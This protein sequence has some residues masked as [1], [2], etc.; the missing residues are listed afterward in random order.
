MVGDRQRPRRLVDHVERVGAH[1]AGEEADADHD[2]G[3]GHQ[4][5]RE[6]ILLLTLSHVAVAFVALLALLKPSLPLLVGAGLAALTAGALAVRDYG[7][8]AFVAVMSVPLAVIGMVL[9]AFAWGHRHDARHGMRPFIAL[10]ALAA[11]VAVAAVTMNGVDLLRLHQSA[12]SMPSATV[13]SVALAGALACSRF[14]GRG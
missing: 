3:D 14:A 6:P 9:L 5:I 4:P 12:R 13:L 2:H 1:V 8:T 10:L 7:D 11:A